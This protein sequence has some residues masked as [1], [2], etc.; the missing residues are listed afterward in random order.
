MD[1][2]DDYISFSEECLSVDGLALVEY[3]LELKA[4]GCS[5]NLAG[6]SGVGNG[7]GGGGGGV[8]GR[9]S[10]QSHLLEQ[11]HVELKHAI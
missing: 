11:V 9:R 2:I 10:L 7:V 8:F 5:I 3:A 1:P 6:A 4:Q